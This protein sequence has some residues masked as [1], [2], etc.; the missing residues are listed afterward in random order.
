MNAWVCA[1]ATDSYLE[2]GLGDRD[3]DSVLSKICRAIQRGQSQT[4]IGHTTDCRKRM[5]ELLGNDMEYQHRLEQANERINHYLAE[6]LEIADKKRKLIPSKTAIDE[7][8]PDR[9]HADQDMADANPQ[10]IGESSSSANAAPPSTETAGDQVS[11]GTKRK[12]GEQ[13]LP[14]ARDRCEQSERGDEIPV[15]EAS[16]SVSPNVREVTT[17]DTR[18]SSGLK[19]PQEGTIGSPL[20][21][22]SRRSRSTRTNVERQIGD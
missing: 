18:A 21:S 3:L 14:D 7:P 16:S 6:E 20:Q 12:A 10:G 5:E 19:R 8:T 22:R 1:R 2:S 13:L 11:E 4:T 17:E 15:P 9:N